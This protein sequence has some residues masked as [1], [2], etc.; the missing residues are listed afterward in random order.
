METGGAAED[1]R[2][3]LSYWKDGDVAEEREV[4]FTEHIYCAK[5]LTSII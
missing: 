2:G 1:P 4:V 3:G 5:S